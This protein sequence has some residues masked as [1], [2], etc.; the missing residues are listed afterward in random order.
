MASGA[1]RR[2]DGTVRCRPPSKA[3]CPKTRWG[4][5]GTRPNHLHWAAGGGTKQANPR[6]PTRSS[7]WKEAQEAGLGGLRRWANATCDVSW[8][9]RDGRCC[10]SQEKERGPDWNP[11]G[12]LGWAGWLSGSFRRTNSSYLLLSALSVPN[13][14]PLMRLVL[15][16]YQRQSGE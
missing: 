5:A 3:I 7:E 6:Y 10:Q 13:T 16:S 14:D 1:L 2:A 4:R 15:S 8:A 12:F 9:R 11:Q